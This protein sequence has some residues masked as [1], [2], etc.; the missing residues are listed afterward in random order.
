MSVPDT[1][2]GVIDPLGELAVEAMSDMYTERGKAFRRAVAKG[3]IHVIREPGAYVEVDNAIVLGANLHGRVTN[4]SYVV[5]VGNGGGG[6]LVTRDSVVVGNGVRVISHGNTTVRGRGT[7]VTTAGKSRRAATTV[8]R[9]KDV[10]KRRKFTTSVDG[11]TTAQTSA[12]V[13]LASLRV[14]SSSSRSHLSP[15]RS[16]GQGLAK[17]M[18]KKSNRR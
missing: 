12:G 7:R 17:K 8:S 2:A 14:A 3:R 18:S 10:K 4:G 9:G 1:L 6:S 13:R 5:D 16:K 15:R 11:P